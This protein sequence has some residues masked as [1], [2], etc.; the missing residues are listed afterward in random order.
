VY[1]G[2]TAP[3]R[4]LKGAEKWSRDHNENWKF[5]YSHT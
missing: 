3:A 1:G 5:A 2:A 4:P